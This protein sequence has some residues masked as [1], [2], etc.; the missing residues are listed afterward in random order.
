MGF[1]NIQRGNVMQIFGIENCF[2]IL[3]VD[4]D[5]WCKRYE[6]TVFEGKCSECGKKST[7]NRAFFA[8][9]GVR[10][11]FCS[12]CECGNDQLP[13]TMISDDFKL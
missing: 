10:G 5:A 7:A 3:N 6:I 4:I 11:L 2:E 12:P 13:F 9:N 8:Q 1:Y